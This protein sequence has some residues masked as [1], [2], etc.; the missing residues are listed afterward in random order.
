MKKIVLLA[1][2]LS[3]PL[4]A[5]KTPGGGIPPT[6]PTPSE[7]VIIAAEIAAAPRADRVEIAAGVAAEV[8]ARFACPTGLALELFL[9][10]RLSFDLFVRGRI[11]AQ[12]GDIIDRLRLRTNDVC[13]IVVEPIPAPAN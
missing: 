4:A 6:A 13:G 2:A 8:G 10:A 1:L 3:V 12:S 11:T 5:C 9:A 7:A